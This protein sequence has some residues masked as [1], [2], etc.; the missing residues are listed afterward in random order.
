[1]PRLGRL[2]AEDLTEEEHKRRADL[3]DGMMQDFKRQVA[4]RLSAGGPLPKRKQR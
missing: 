2:A 1:M 4:A 3:A